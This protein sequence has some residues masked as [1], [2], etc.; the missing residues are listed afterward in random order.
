MN[1]RAGWAGSRPGSGQSCPSLT[2]AGRLWATAI[3][4]RA[5]NRTQRTDPATQAVGNCH[6]SQG[7]GPHKEDRS[8]NSVNHKEVKF[9][10]FTGEVR[11]HKGK[12]WGTAL[13]K[14]FNG[15]GRADPPVMR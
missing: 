5:M 6:H 15:G 12:L 10:K 8:S 2:A 1:L 3:T 7:H 11:S 4:D 9:S 13:G 14:L